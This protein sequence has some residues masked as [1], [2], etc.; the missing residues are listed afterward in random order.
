MRAYTTVLCSL[1]I[2]H[3]Q[4]PQVDVVS[5]EATRVQLAEALLDAGAHYAEADRLRVRLLRTMGERNRAVLQRNAAR[6]QCTAF[7]RDVA[8][9][10]M[11]AEGSG[12]L[13]TAKVCALDHSL[14]VAIAIAVTAIY[15][16]SIAP[17][18]PTAVCSAAYPV[19]LATAVLNCM[20][21]IVHVQ[22]ADVARLE[23][24]LLAI[25]AHMVDTHVSQAVLLLVLQ[26]DALLQR[27]CAQCNTLCSVLHP[28]LCTIRLD[29]ALAGF[30]FFA[31]LSFQLCQKAERYDMLQ[32]VAE[33][34]VAV[35]DRHIEYVTHCTLT[36]HTVCQCG[37]LYHNCTAHTCASMLY[38]LCTLKRARRAQ[39]ASE[40]AEQSEQRRQL[41][42]ERANDVQSLQRMLYI[43][44]SLLVVP[45]SQCLR[46]DTC[47]AGWRASQQLMQNCSCSTML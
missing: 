40:H 29:A 12:Q 22:D 7:A 1:L 33:Q 36:L 38:T 6:Q 31:Q 35:R 26:A 14:L 45:H 27:C 18:A 25:R 11:A 37:M 15:D 20:L 5:Q 2:S 8:V 10:E 30:A 19:L 47:V 24:Q 34:C 44:Q 43:K 17:P 9:L 23:D 21:S 16:T 13:L 4:Q 32:Y 42:V 3:T 39:R 41:L 46:A 28:C